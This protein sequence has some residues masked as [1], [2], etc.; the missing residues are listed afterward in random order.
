MEE[1]DVFYKEIF[2]IFTL[3]VKISY[4]AISSLLKNRF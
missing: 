3:Y 2:A 4:K 1:T